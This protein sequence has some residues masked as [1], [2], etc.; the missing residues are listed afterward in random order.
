MEEALCDED[1]EKDPEWRRPPPPHNRG[2]PP[3]PHEMMDREPVRGG[4]QMGRAM[5]KGMQHSPGAPHE[6]YEEGRRE[7]IVEDYGHGESR[8]GWRPP[9]EYPN[10][11]YDPERR[12]HDPEWNRE[13]PTP[14]RDFSPRMPPPERFRDDAWP[15]E[16]ERV[17]PYPYEEPERARGELRIREYREEPPHSEWERSAR[18]PPPPIPERTYP[19]EYEEPRPHYGDHRGE[20]AHAMDA[21]AAPQ[22]AVPVANHPEAPLDSVAQGGSTAGVLALSQRQHEIILKAAQELK[23]IR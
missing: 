23:F 20:P 11:D 8:Y 6:K 2:P 10:D 19:P 13:R 14:A 18:P 1:M 21:M 16:R 17:R 4:P 12:Y 15:E 3:A 5:G 7:A 22:L 9:R